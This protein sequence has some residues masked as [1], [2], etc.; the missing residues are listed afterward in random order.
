VS[1]LTQGVVA[2]GFGIQPGAIDVVA[3]LNRKFKVE[4]KRPVP[5]PKEV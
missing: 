4:C 2:D 3:A 5:D 1:E